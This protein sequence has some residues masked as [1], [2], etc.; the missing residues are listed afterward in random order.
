MQQSLRTLW[1]WRKYK[2]KGWGA[3]SRRM[4]SK[5]QREL[6][7]L[8]PSPETLN[9]PN[10]KITGVFFKSLVWFWSQSTHE[11]VPVPKNHY[12]EPGGQFHPGSTTRPP[13]WSR[14]LTGS[15]GQNQFQFGFNYPKPEPPVRKFLTDNSGTCPTLV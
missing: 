5:E 7:L 9:P 1:A 12:L 11:P 3:R 6:P 10:L 13:S 2:E 4:R 15:W 14:F 8:L